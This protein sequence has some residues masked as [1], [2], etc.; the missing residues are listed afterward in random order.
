MGPHEP[1]RSVHGDVVVFVCD[2]AFHAPL[3]GRWNA[4]RVLAHLVAI[5]R[6]VAATPAELLPG[7]ISVVDYPGR[8]NPSH[9]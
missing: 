5:D 7:G 3:S 8:C 9:T 1:I 6:M 4:D 2:R